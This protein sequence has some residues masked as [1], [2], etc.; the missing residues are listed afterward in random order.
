MDTAISNQS[1]SGVRFSGGGGSTRVLDHGRSDAPA[2][3]TGHD[4]LPELAPTIAA[5][6]TRGRC[7]WIRYSCLYRDER[8]LRNV[9]LASV[10]GDLRVALKVGGEFYRVMFESRSLR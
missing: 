3:I 7:R 2:D 8:D 4:R 5:G 10:A 9:V 6:S 1:A